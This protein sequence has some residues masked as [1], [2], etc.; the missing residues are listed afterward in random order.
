MAE[1]VFR[2]PNGLFGVFSSI[3]D[4][5][6]WIN[7]TERAVLLHFRTRMSERE[8]EQKLWRGVADLTPGLH[9]HYAGRQE[10]T[11]DGLERYRDTLACMGAGRK[12]ETLIQDVT[13]PITHRWSWHCA[14]CDN[15]VSEVYGCPPAACCVGPA[16]VPWLAPDDPRA[17]ELPPDHSDADDRVVFCAAIYGGSI[18]GRAGELAWVLPPEG[19]YGAIIRKFREGA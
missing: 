5:P 10:P 7:A 13:P 6:T 19:V 9:R 2:Q 8:A 4:S 16:L 12:R 18:A 1:S 14:S 17:G 11:G 15:D 3:T